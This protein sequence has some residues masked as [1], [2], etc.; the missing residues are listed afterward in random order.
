MSFSNLP[1]D[2]VDFKAQ[3]YILGVNKKATNDAVLG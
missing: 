1:C 2:K 3:K